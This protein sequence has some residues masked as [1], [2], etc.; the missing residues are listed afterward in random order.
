[1]DTSTGERSRV[2]IK[3]FTVKFVSSNAG[4]TFSQ[5]TKIIVIERLAVEMQ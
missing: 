5:S 4:M 2:F 3:K 1:M